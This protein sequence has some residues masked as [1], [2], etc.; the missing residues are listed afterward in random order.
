VNQ[1]RG[2]D[3]SGVKKTV[4]VGEVRR[5]L[6]KK[7]GAKDTQGLEKEW[8]EFISGIAIE[9][10]EAR[11]KRA[12]SNVMLGHLGKDA[13]SRDK[14]VEETLA[15][16]DFAIENGFKD[17][18][19]FWVRGQLKAYFVGNLGGATEDLKQAI[20]LDP[21]NP[22]YRFD[23]GRVLSG[24]L[25]IMASAS[26]ETGVAGPRLMGSNDELDE[27]R[28]QFGLACELDRENDLYSEAFEKYCSL[29][30]KQR[31]K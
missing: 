7:L 16:L 10:P 11:F 2:G 13:E 21:L 1:E 27:A 3:K 14:A 25:F 9:A 26:P 18:R 6:L 19:A 17:A 8:K 31:S 5:L 12:Y 22:A 4:P 28:S 23:M 15:D 29:Y 20:E 30:E 24:G